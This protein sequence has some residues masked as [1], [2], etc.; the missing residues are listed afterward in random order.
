[1]KRSPLHRSP[2]GRG[3]SRK[4]KTGSLEGKVN[5]VNG[6]SKRRTLEDMTHPELEKLLDAE[7]SFFVRANPALHSA[8]PGFVRCY[9]CGIWYHWKALDCGHFIPRHHQGTRFDLRNLRPQCTKCNCYHEGEHWQYRINL[10][11]EI[12]ED[13]V[14]G[15]EFAASIWGGQRHPRGWLIEKIEDWRERNKPL[16]AQVKELE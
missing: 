1:M 5:R 16:R 14:E 4:T 11:A 2:F 9:T 6:A 13:E 8:H 12:G 10:V 3:I 15:L 7:I